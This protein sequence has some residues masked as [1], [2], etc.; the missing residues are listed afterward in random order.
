MRRR[1]HTRTCRKNLGRSWSVNVTHQYIRVF[2]FFDWSVSIVWFSN[3]Y[4]SSIVQFIVHELSR[5]ST[6]IYYNLFLGT[7]STM[8][9][10]NTFALYASVSILINFLLQI[11][12][13]VCL[14]SL[15]E[16]RFEVRFRRVFVLKRKKEKFS[17]FSLHVSEKIFRRALLPE[18]EDGQFYNRAKIQYHA[19]YFWTLL[20][21]ISYENAGQ[22]N[23]ID[24]I[25][26]LSDNAYRNSAANWYRIGAKTFDARRFLCFEILRGNILHYV[27]I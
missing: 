4:N 2:V 13:F 26:H 25:L 7:L 16:R 18:N 6:I 11:T 15:H 10:V 3:N 23:R 19:Y 22:N 21:A 24:N 9:A 17:N 5:I 12:A 20:H 27:C 14:L 8:P 1:N